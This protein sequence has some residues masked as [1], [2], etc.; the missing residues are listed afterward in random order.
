MQIRLFILYKFILLLDTIEIK[1]TPPAPQ[2]LCEAWQTPRTAH[3]KIIK[4]TASK[5]LNAC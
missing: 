5:Q 1:C 4:I 3:F 2:H